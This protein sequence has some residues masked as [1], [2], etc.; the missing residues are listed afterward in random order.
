MPPQMVKAFF[1]MTA[2][3][4]PVTT[5]LCAFNSSVSRYMQIHCYITTPRGHWGLRQYIH[6]GSIY[7]SCMDSCTFKQIKKVQSVF[8]DST[9]VFL[10]IRSAEMWLTPQTFT[11][12]QHI[13]KYR[14]CQNSRKHHDGI[15][16]PTLHTSD[17]AECSSFRFMNRKIRV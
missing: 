11:S 6:R 7:A 1:Q 8:C 14:C 4:K 3:L 15:F 5:K 10:C 13:I 16:L 17:C 12:S 9:T 2:N